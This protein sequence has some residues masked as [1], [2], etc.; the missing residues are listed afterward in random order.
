MAFTVKVDFLK[1]QS[2]IALSMRQDRKCFWDPVRRKWYLITPEEWLRQLVLQ[3]LICEKSYPKRLLAVEK[4]FRQLDLSRRFDI[5]AYDPA[6]HPYLIV[7]CKS[8]LIGLTGAAFRQIAYYN[9]AFQAPYLMVTNGRKTFCAQLNHEEK[10]FLFL[11][12]I[13]AFPVV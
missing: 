4:T 9:L 13:P 2:G 3:F 6:H 1:H 5:L 7:E 10:T 12:D 8:P 11:N